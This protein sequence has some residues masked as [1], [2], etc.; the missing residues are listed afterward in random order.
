MVSRASL[1]LNFPRPRS[2]WFSIGYTD[3]A[4]N[5]QGR[6]IEHQGFV[7]PRSNVADFLYGMHYLQFPGASGW[8]YT[9]AGLLSGVLLLT[10]VKVADPNDDTEP[11]R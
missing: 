5:D 4:G 11:K 10:I 9:L 8:L 2:P 1:R 6:Y 3:G 7:E